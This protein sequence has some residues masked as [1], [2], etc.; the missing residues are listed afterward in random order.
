[1]GEE[2]TSVADGAAADGCFGAARFDLVFFD[3]QMVAISE[4]RHSTESIGKRDT[5]T[6][7][8]TAGI[9]RSTRMVT[10]LAVVAVTLRNTCRMELTGMPSTSKIISPGRNPASSAA[11]PGSVLTTTTPAG[12]APTRSATISS[13]GE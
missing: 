4:L 8:L 5:R 13:I 10:Y 7:D 11:D 3:D 1:M 12:L 2:N 9:K 6:L